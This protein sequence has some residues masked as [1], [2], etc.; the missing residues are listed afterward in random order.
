MLFA[1]FVA[2]QHTSTNH[3]HEVRGDEATCTSNMQAEHFIAREPGDRLADGA[4]RWTI[5]GYYTN[6]L[7]RT[8][9][10]WKL[11]KVALNVTWQTG[12]REVSRIALRRGRAIETSESPSRSK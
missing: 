1:G 12:N 5:G 3:V 8:A 10:G 4:D 11:A 9:D 2:T 6:E 7:V